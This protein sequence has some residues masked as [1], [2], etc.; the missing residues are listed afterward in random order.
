MSWQAVPRV[1]EEPMADP[2]RSKR[3]VDAFLKMRK[4]D[5]ETLLKA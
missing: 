5:I 2:D 1:L 4:F 3:V